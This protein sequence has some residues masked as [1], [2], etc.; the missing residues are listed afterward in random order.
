MTRTELEQAMKPFRQVDAPE[1][2][3]RGDGTGLGLP[4]TKAMAEANRAAFLDQ[5]GAERRHA[6]RNYLPVATGAGRLAT[7]VG[8][9]QTDDSGRFLPVIVDEKKR[10]LK[11]ASIVL[12]AKQVH[13]K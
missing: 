8:V 3:K 10:Q 6:G 9:R 12:N 11:A 4:L 5:F 2:R 13:E 7:I 1:S